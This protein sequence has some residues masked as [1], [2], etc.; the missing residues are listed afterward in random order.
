M[1]ERGLQIPD[2]DK[3]IHYLKYI[4]YYRL[5][6]Y[7]LSFQHGAKGDHTFLNGTSFD[8]VLRLYI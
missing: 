5:T 2:P 4:G 3:A 7:C 8:D 6:G 1:E